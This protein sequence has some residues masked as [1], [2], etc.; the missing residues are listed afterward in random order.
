MFTDKEFRNCMGE[1][2]TG[3]CVITAKNKNNEPY[4]VTINSFSSV[5]L[6]PVLILYCMDKKSD[7][8]QNIVDFEHF[9]VHILSENQL[10]ISNSFAKPANVD[11]Q[12]IDHKIDDNGNPVISNCNAVISCEKYNILDGGDHSIILGKVLDIHIDSNHPP[13]IYY[14]GKYDK[15]G[16]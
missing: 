12:N 14:K 2:A 13:L 8:Y 15:L 10:K 16:D 11:W 4:G 9:N 6:D 7:N 5:S 1:F 3:I